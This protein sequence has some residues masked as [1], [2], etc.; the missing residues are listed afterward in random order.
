MVITKSF[1]NLDADKQKRILNA[2]LK[3]FSENGYDKASTNRIVKEA[4]I[5]KG[6]LFYYFKNKEELYYYLINYAVDMMTNE[7]FSL[8]DM[9]EPDFIER[10]KKSV[11]VKIA[12]YADNPHVNNF[13]GALF[14]TDKLELSAD[15]ETRFEEMQRLGFSILYADIDHSLF[16]ED[17]D[18]DKAFQLIRW[19]IEGYQNELI[20]KF[21]GQ[22]VTS[23]DMDPVL[24]E[25]DE[26]LNIFKT[27]FYKQEGD[28]Q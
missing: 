25:F 1:N 24:E 26:Y 28:T 19:S 10:L 8:I 3:E 11:Q 18:V 22:K 15:L 21:K 16:R 4:G 23:I 7:Y 20:N 2:A 5:G 9:K 13:L 14:L 17:I 12:F 6:M 27:S